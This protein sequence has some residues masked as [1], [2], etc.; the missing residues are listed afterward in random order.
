MIYDNE[1]TIRFKAVPENEKFARTSVA[2]FISP[3]NPTLN[4]INDI[5]TAVSEAVTNSIIHGYDNGFG[6][7]FLKC[8]IKAN[9]VYIKIEDR[10][11]GIK[12]IEEAMSPLYTTKPDL[13]RSGLGFTVMEAFMDKISVSSEVGKRTIIEMSKTIQYENTAEQQ[14]I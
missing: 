13:G 11:K 14:A 8:G 2:V 7:I 9:T 10:G 5:K 12:N 3:L 4:D 1:M 6:E